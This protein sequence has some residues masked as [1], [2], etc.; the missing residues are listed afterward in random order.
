MS[1]FPAGLSGS[2]GFQQYRDLNPIYSSK[3]FLREA[4]ET[5]AALGLKTCNS[6]LGSAMAE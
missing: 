2:H 3:V 5:I 1:F 4:E 6:V